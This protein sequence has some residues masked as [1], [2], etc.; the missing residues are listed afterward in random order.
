VNWLVEFNVSGHVDMNEVDIGLQVLK[1]EIAKPVRE[2]MPVLNAERTLS[3]TLMPS[4]AVLASGN[5]NAPESPVLSSAFKTVTPASIHNRN[6]I[7]GERLMFRMA[8]PDL[9]FY[10][11]CM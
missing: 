8:S 5:V 6:N 3:S 9:L 4:Q 10:G 2:R 11:E 1:A 7:K